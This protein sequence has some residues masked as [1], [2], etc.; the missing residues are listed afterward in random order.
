MLRA[1]NATR[2]ADLLDE[3]HYRI[4]ETG[5]DNWNGGTTIYKLFLSVPPHT[6]VALEPDKAKL[7][8]QI[9]ERLCQLIE[10]DVQCWIS[11]SIIPALLSDADAQQHTGATRIIQEMPSPFSKTSLMPAQRTL[12]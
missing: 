1:G 11:A 3:S 8:E 6:Y 9:T 10:P 2:A 12:A 7:E 5:Y 4:E